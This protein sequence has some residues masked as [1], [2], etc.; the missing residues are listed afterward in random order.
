MFV[1]IRWTKT[2][3]GYRKHAFVA[4]ILLHCGEARTKH[5]S[6]VV[7]DN[8]K[9]KM[10]VIELTNEFNLQAG[11]TAI[12]NQHKRV[13]NVDVN[14][15]E[16]PKGS[17]A[18][19]KMNTDEIY[20]HPVVLE[21]NNETIK[22]FTLHEVGHAILQTSDHYPNTIMNPVM[23]WDGTFSEA[24][25]QLLSILEEEGKHPCK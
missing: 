5:F 15:D 18:C 19:W 3:A 11:C 21:W 7:V 13:I 1:S 4:L 22:L 10:A 17:A 20:L 25:S 14:E 8:E 24:V 16:V 23:L 9:L 12:S 6:L 2:K